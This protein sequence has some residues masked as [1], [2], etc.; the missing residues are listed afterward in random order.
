M[1][2]HSAL[3]TATLRSDRWQEVR[4]DAIRRAGY[5]CARC[6][7]GNRPLDGHHLTYRHLGQ[8]RPG[9]VVAL[10][11]ACHDGLHRRTRWLKRPLVV[12][13]WLVVVLLVAAAVGSR[14]A[15]AQE[16]Q[17]KMAYVIDSSGGLL[18]VTTSGRW[19]VALQGCDVPRPWTEVVLSADDTTL[20]LGSGEACTISTARYVDPT[21]CATEAHGLCDVDLEPRG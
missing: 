21:P 8:E 19:L 7:R 17:G 10:C 3:Y 5:R 15:H 2:R 6:R 11:R 13:I 1:R 12:A 9:E 18:L 20:L 14:L 16:Q 4:H